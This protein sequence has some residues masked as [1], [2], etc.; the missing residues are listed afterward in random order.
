MAVVPVIILDNGAA[1]HGLQYMEEFISAEMG[2][3]SPS[4]RLTQDNLP[5]GRGGGGKCGGNSQYQSGK[6]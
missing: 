6:Q 5:V 2:A 1:I 4:I 3:E